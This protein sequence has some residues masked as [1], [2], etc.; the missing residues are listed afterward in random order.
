MPRPVPTQSLLDHYLFDPSFAL[1]NAARHGD[2]TLIKSLVA[3]GHDA[4]YQ[5]PLQYGTPLHVAI[6]CDQLPSVLTLLLSGADLEAVTPNHVRIDTGHTG[7]DSLRM[8]VRWGR[9]EIVKVLWN[10]GVKGSSLNE[11]DA[12]D[13]EGPWERRLPGLL[14]IAAWEGHI[15]VVRDLLEWRRTWTREEIDVAFV[16]AARIWV[17][18]LVGT[19]ME[20]HIFFQEVLREALTEALD[21]GPTTQFRG[22]PPKYDNNDYMVSRSMDEARTIELLLEAGVDVDLDEL[23]RR[24]SF[25]PCEIETMKM[26]LKRGA[27]VSAMDRNGWTPRRRRLPGGQ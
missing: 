23:L 6:A 7:D 8:A 2:T 3:S 18:D 14:E 21:N 26:L 11:K 12:R 5:E 10:L 22:R 9:R 17:Y 15:D 16:N 4:N 25:R 13:A 20:S 19:L 27:D 1:H 24:V